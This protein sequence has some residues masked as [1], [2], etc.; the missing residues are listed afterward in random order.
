MICVGGPISGGSFNP[1]VTIAQ[2]ITKDINA[3]RGAI[4]MLAQIVGSF[5]GGLLLLI[6]E[7]DNFTGPDF[8]SPTLSPN[9]SQFGGIVVEF[10]ATFTLVYMVYTGVR[11]K[12]SEIVIGAWVGGAL[13]TMINA[14]GP[15]TGASLNP[16]RTL[17]PFMVK[18]GFVP[19]NTETQP[20]LV[21]YVAP[22]LG[23]I[24]AGLL[25]KYFIHADKHLNQPMMKKV[26]MTK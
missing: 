8:T 6:I 22:I 3:V 12:K 18:N 7:P 4:F 16:C 24:C 19:L 5:L 11:T 23:G 2:M 13:F 17:G 14:I 9:I 10:I 1:A 15:L 21:Y 26:E 25:S 20:I